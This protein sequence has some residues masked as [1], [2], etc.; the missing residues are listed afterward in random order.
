MFSPEQRLD[1]FTIRKINWAS[2]SQAT[3]F[4]LGEYNLLPSILMLRFRNC[5]KIN[6]EEVISY[7]FPIQIL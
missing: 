6:F 3:Y 7:R 1:V 2:S 5:E 4:K